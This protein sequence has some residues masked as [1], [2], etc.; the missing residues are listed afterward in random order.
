MVL[1]VKNFLEKNTT[2][3]KAEFKEKYDGYLQNFFGGKAD[4]GR[5]GFA[6]GSI[7]NDSEDIKKLKKLISGDIIEN[8]KPDMSDMDDL[9]A[10]TGIN[11]SRQ[12]KS[13]LFRRLGGSGGA[14]RS[15]TMPNLYRILN[16]P[17]DT[18]KM[19]EY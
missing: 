8:E 2:K 5:I 12:E 14:D 7:D 18:L 13:Y 1:L 9:M 19:L 10:G 4:G 11:F 15:Y 16:N 6:K 3:A 17:V